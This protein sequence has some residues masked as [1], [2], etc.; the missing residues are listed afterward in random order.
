MRRATVR[1]AMEKSR[2]VRVIEGKE[3]SGDDQIECFFLGG[4]KVAFESQRG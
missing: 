4:S 1:G 2:H 3:V